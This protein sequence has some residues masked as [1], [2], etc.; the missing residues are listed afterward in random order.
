M[1]LP[2]AVLMSLHTGIRPDRR[3]GLATSTEKTGD[4]EGT[5]TGSTA[6]QRIRKM[7][8]QGV[9]RRIQTNR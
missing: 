7:R 6:G 2:E 4:C 9:T 8:L 3:S 1:S 5:N